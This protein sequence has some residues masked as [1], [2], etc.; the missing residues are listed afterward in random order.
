MMNASKR[1]FYVII[2]RDED[3]YYVGEVPQLTACYSQ[4]ET[5]DELM[6]N[7]KE[8]IELCLEAESDEPIP[9]FVGIQKVVI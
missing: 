6:T 1:E 2:E 8:V 7:I 9:E 5:I 3:G 4:G